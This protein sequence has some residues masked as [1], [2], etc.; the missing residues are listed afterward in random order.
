MHSAFHKAKKLVKSRKIDSS[1]VKA[2]TQQES[3]SRHNEPDTD[4]SA[5]ELKEF[6]ELEIKV[7]QQSKPDWLQLMQ[8][9]NKLKG[10]STK[11][12]IMGV[13]RQP[14]IATISPDLA[15][16]S[17]LRASAHDQ[18]GTKES[19]KGDVI[20]QSAVS[21]LELNNG[22]NT[23]YSKT[24]L[25]ST[26]SLINASRKR[27]FTHT[28]ERPSPLIKKKVDLESVEIGTNEVPRENVRKPEVLVGFTSN[29]PFK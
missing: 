26:S 17:K 22:Y 6:L 16:K 3:E 8:N 15:K 2:K 27:S 13:V 5:L 12:L 20:T 23:L 9:R 4:I 25:V 29:F 14:F 21:E 19:K 24:R 10:I 1:E 28:L 11:E 18:L 7:Q